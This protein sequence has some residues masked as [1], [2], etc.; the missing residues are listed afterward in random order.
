MDLTITLNNTSVEEIERLS[1]LVG[2][3]SSAPQNI[4]PVVHFGDGRRALL[5]ADRPVA[6]APNQHQLV[7]GIHRVAYV[8][9]PAPTHYDRTVTTQVGATYTER[10]VLVD[11][12][13]RD[14]FVYDGWNAEHLDPSTLP[15]NERLSDP[16]SDKAGINARDAYLTAIGGDPWIGKLVYSYQSPPTMTEIA[17]LSPTPS[18]YTTRTF[19][20]TRDGTNDLGR[21]FREIHETA[22]GEIVVDEYWLFDPAWTP[23]PVGKFMGVERITGSG[24][25]TDLKDFLTDNG[26]NPAYS[27]YVQGTI[28]LKLA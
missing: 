9:Q 15:T 4:G 18:S 24:E 26:G 10:F 14:R 1:R 19:K 20:V 16:N 3:G 5:G 27:I 25:Y 21:L 13:S 2:G 11:K 28:N 6:V 17:K 12:T 7:P 22:Y 23:P 8:G